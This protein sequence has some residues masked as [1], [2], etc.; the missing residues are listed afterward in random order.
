MPSD[1][2]RFRIVGPP[3]FISRSLRLTVTER[4]RGIAGG[5]EPGP[6]CGPGT[7][8]LAGCARRAAM[9]GGK[10]DVQTAADYGTVVILELL[11]P[12]C[13]S[14]RELYT[15]KSHLMQKE[16]VL[17]FLRVVHGGWMSQ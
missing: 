2:R 13:V 3:D 1:M 17:F 9:I 6:L 8:G 14:M 5:V 15:E 7:P 12:D 11:L 16:D 10:L 4:R